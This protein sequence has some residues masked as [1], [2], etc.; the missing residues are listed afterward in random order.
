MISEITPAWLKRHCPHLFERYSSLDDP[1]NPQVALTSVFGMP[2]WHRV[3]GEALVTR[4]LPEVLRPTSVFPVD[5]PDGRTI[6]LPQ[7]GPTF[8]TWRGGPVFSYGRKPLLTWDGKPIFAELLV[9]RLLQQ[10]G[11]EGV[12]ASPYGG[13]KYVTG[14][15]SDSMMRGVTTSLHADKIRLLDDI[16]RASSQRTGGCFYILAWRGPDILFC[17]CKRK[18]KD[19]LRPTQLAWIESAS[20]VVPIQSLLLVEWVG[21]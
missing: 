14:M 10:C 1:T 13:E 9:L 16:R 18:G 20:R 7:C 3:C 5:L 6:E 8:E 17:K 2:N 4:Y 12:W 19:V 11:W 21:T 15:P